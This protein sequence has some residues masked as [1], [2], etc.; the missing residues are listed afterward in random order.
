[1]SELSLLVVPALVLGA[2][3]A[4]TITVEAH[5]WPQVSIDTKVRVLGVDTPEIRGA[6]PAEK[7]LAEAARDYVR[8]LLIG[9]WVTLRLIT[10]DKYGG[11]F[12]ASVEVEGESLTRLLIEKDYGVAYWGGTKTK[13]WCS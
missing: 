2:Y 9:K 10:L 1:M 5:P 8:D 11:R 3:D 12:V 6:C 13:D 4:D 7:S